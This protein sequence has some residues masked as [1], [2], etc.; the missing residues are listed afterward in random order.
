LFEQLTDRFSEVFRKIRGRG[1]ISEANVRDVMDDVR[2]ALL[3]AD[4]HVGVARRFCDQVLQKAIGAEVVKTLHPDQVM[5]KIVHDEL[6]SLLGPVDPRIP[7]VLPPP[8]I[9]LLAGLQ[10]SGKTTTA[11]KLARLVMKKGKRP[12]LVAADL[13]RPAAIDQLE[14]IGAQVG[15]PVY[16]ERGHQNVV[17]LC[18]N[19]VVHAR[20]TDHDVV[21]LDTAGRLAIDE[22]MMQEVRQVAQSIQPHQVY[23]VI[24]A[25]TGQDAVNTAKAFND[26]LELD[27]VILTKF[28]SDTRGGAALSVKSITGKPIKFIGTGEKPDNLEEFHADRIAGRIL[29]MGDIVTLVEKAQSQVKAE[30]A[31]RL[32]EKMAKGS[33]SLDDFMVQ[34]EKMQNI[35]TMRQLLKMIPGLGSEMKDME[36]DED[37]IK[38]MRAIIQSMTPKER[39]NP[40][41]IDAS[42]RRRIARGSGTD[43]VD[44]SGLVKSFLQARDMMKIMAGM[45]FTD[46]LRMGTQFAQMSAIS[47]KMPQIRIKGTTVKKR[48]LT[49]KDKRKRRRR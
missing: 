42:R 10:G 36:V 28:D 29:G 18:R 13:K 17:A 15:V 41:I 24:D 30:E 35:G 44:V 26:R 7:F 37:E 12:I 43:P 32:Q 9:I 4:V 34:M 5:V 33:F 47:G 46:R 25:M 40:A 49:Q 21:V 31:A 45:S 16:S 39:S 22:E 27:G 2:T 1:R 6:V 14:V 8:T 19:A 20:Q 11:G 38:R 48:R 3:E 23:L